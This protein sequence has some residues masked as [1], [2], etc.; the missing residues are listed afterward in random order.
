MK[1]KIVAFLSIMTPLVT[2]TTLIFRVPIPATQGYF[3]LGD[4]TVIL[5]GIM[6]GPYPGLIAGGV[7]SAL[8][9][10][11]SGYPH[12]APITFVAKGGEGAIAG[13][14]FKKF[15]GRRRLKYASGLLGGAFMVASYFLFELQFFGLGGAL[16]EAP[17]NV[18]QCALGNLV[19]YTAHSILEPTL[20]RR[21][22]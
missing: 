3:N 22:R 19:A 8:A 12:Y 6:F 2:A 17:L 14:T 18:L 16:V 5:T 1:A 4:A 9:D 10:I 13:F 11:I 7:G 21:L 15:Y 20:S